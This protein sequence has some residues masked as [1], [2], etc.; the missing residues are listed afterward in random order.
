[1]HIWTL[2]VGDAVEVWSASRRAW[3]LGTIREIVQPGNI[4]SC[5]G[6]PLAREGAV[7]VKFGKILEKWVAP[8]DLDTVLRRHIPWEAPSDPEA[9]P[10]SVLCAVRRMF[11]QDRYP[12]TA[13]SAVTARELAGIWVTALEEETNRSLTL[14]AEGLIRSKVERAFEELGV[15]SSGR[16]GINDWVHYA[17]L[18]YHPPGPDTLQ[19]ISSELRRLQPRA[20]FRLVSL[21]MRI[22]TEG[23]GFVCCADIS[24][25]LKEIWAPGPLAEAQAKT[26]L[27]DMDGDGYGYASYSEFACRFLNLKYSQVSLYWYDLSNDWARYLSPLLLG[28]WEGGIWHTGLCV[29][30]QEYYF[31]GRVQWEEPGDTGFGTPV[32]VLKL[33]V[34][35]RTVDNFHGHIKTELEQQFH[36]KAYDVFDHN[37]NHFVHEAARFLLGRGIPDEVRLQPQRVMNTPVAR[38]FRPLLNRCLGRVDSSDNVAPASNKIAQ[39]VVDKVSIKKKKE[40]IYI[41]DVDEDFKVDDEGRLQD[42]R[43]KRLSRGPHTKGGA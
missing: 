41:I 31:G 8:V 15:E 40:S 14:E 26:M 43:N 6:G 35:L 16:V 24:Q 2:H 37:C 19:R 42:P 33:G 20:L 38:I 32:K 10:S 13:D 9:P 3:F 7:K 4:G 27:R 11:Y 21:W 34:T 36:S 12:A 39:A 25:A 1:M 29:F 22:D 28:S 23:T 18:L 5:S 17:L 30:G